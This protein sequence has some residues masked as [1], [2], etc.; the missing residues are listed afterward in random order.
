LVIVFA[1][2]V[3]EEELLG[4]VYEAGCAGD[5]ATLRSLSLK[6]ASG[7]VD[8]ANRLLDGAEASARSLVKQYDKTIRRFALRL[9]AKR[10]FILDQAEAA[11]RQAHEE[12][13][14]RDAVLDAEW[15]AKIDKAR[16]RSLVREYKQQQATKA[17][18]IAKGGKV[19]RTF[20][21]SNPKDAA[22]FAHKMGFERDA[23]LKGHVAGHVVARDGQ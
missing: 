19:I 2:R 7:N 21:M 5:D 10:E 23:E 17:L 14:K 9:A 1:G 8:A 18:P 12:A 13:T 4:D 15:H 22:D 11:I 20:D 16:A 3:A 6:L